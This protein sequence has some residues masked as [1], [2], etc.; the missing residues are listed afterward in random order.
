MTLLLPPLQLSPLLSNLLKT[1]SRFS[2]THSFIFIQFAVDTFNGSV[3]RLT[4][5]ERKQMGSYLCIASNEV[6]P[7]VSKRISLSVHCNA[8]KLFPI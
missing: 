7:A 5:L 2:L 1:H 3:L 8:K 4:R 6:P